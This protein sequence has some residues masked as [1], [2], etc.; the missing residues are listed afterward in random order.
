[1]FFGYKT[2]ELLYKYNVEICNLEKTGLGDVTHTQ[3]CTHTHTHAHTYTYVRRRRKKVGLSFT[4]LSEIRIAKAAKNNFSRNDQS[5]SRSI[6]AVQ[7]SI[8]ERIHH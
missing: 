3:R 8:Y 1:M 6:T 2:P 5:E 7:K 4:K